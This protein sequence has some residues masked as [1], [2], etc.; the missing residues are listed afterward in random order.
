MRLKCGV[1]VN[2]HRCRKEMSA[3]CGNNCCIIHCQAMTESTCV[4]HE[5][6]KIQRELKRR[7]KVREKGQENPVKVVPQSS[8]IID[9]TGTES[10]NDQERIFHLR[11]GCPS[12]SLTQQNPKK[13]KATDE[14]KP[15][16]VVCYYNSVTVLP[17]GHFLCTDCHTQML[18]KSKTIKLD[19]PVCKNPFQDTI[20]LF[21]S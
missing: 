21:Y 16:C 8:F 15:A 4:Y 9:M 6:Y 10:Q 1:L 3:K 20:K 2:G 13:R 5:N 14:P 18:S 19:C 7:E 12:F 17:C 11:F